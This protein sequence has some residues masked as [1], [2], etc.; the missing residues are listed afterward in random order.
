[1]LEEAG[2]SPLYLLDDLDAELAPPTVAAVWNVFQPARQLIATSNRPQV[3][4]T[5][6]VGRV[7]E[8][9]KGELR[10]NS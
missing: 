4:L 3:W 7:W 10:L 1:V 5:L 2:R 6:E 9:E 8:M